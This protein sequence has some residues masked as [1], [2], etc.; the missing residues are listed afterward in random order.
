MI[1]GGL[2]TDAVNTVNAASKPIMIV[3]V[4]TT[5]T[6]IQLTCQ[7]KVQQKVQLRSQ[8][9]KTWTRLSLKSFKW[10]QRT[11]TIYSS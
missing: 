10:L 9:L 8:L 5:E 1:A 3:G 4:D 11:R 2:I 7:N 6:I